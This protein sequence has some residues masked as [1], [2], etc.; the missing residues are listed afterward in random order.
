[1]LWIA[2]H[3]QFDPEMLGYLPYMFD[4]RDP[5]PAREQAN[6]NYSPMGWSPMKGF[7]MLPNGDLAYPGDPPTKLLAET[8]LHANYVNPLDTTKQEIIRFYEHAWVV[9][10]QPDGS[11][12]VSRMD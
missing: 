6:E 11:W 4:D 3:P 10:I 1:M 7:T 12:E 8:I 5:R 9:I 2:K